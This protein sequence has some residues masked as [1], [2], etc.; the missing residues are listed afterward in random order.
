LIG[1]GNNKYDYED[2]YEG[3]RY[4]PHKLEQIRQDTS[5]ASART[6]PSYAFMGFNITQGSASSGE[7]IPPPPLVVYYPITKRR[8]F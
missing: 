7:S 4:R 3:K 2:I 5:N 8:K 1:K 6:S